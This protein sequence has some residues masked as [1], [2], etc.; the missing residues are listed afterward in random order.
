MEV[1][2]WST[3]EIFWV[4]IVLSASHHATQADCLHLYFPR[5]EGPIVTVFSVDVERPPSPY[6]NQPWLTEEEEEEKRSWETGGE[7]KRREVANLFLVGLSY[8][9]VVHLNPSLQN[10]EKEK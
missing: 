10:Q 8:M 2:V 3:K 4:G 1:C 6:D 7:D 5:A 9:S